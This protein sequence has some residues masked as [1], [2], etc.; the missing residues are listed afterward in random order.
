M[1]FSRAFLAA[2]VLACGPLIAQTP[3]AAPAEAAAPQH[4]LVNP[5]L[6]S[7]PDP[8][9]TYR[10]GSY[11]VMH[12][13]GR[14]LTI[15]KTSRIED[16]ASAE[17][18]VVWRAPAAGPYSRDIWAPELHYLRG[19]WYI[20]F[21]A[22]AG[23]NASHRVWVLE[24]DSADPL[25]GEWRMKGKAA[26]AGDRWAIDATVFEDGKRLFMVWSGWEAGV[27]G[28][29]NLYIAELSNPW[30]VKGARVKISSPEFPWEKVG[31]L[32]Q[33]RDP[34]E[35]P[36]ANRLDPPHVDVNEG[37][38]ILRHG[39]RIFIVYSAAGCWTDNYSLGML[40]AETG[41]DLLRPESWKK[42]PLPVFWQSP[43]AGV[44]GPGHGSFFQ[45]PD[46]A[47]DWLL[48]HANPGPGQGCG[49]RR[50][51]H[52]QRFTWKPDGTPDFGRPIRA[53]ERAAPPSGEV[54]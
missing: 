49:G 1:I 12:T 33:K 27:N 25:A 36:G 11:Y 38:E 37:P 54:P 5:L 28:A 3:Q 34:E 24:N 29:Q 50:A 18:K 4:V 51:P 14:D 52:A 40:A 35:N 32:K 53:G 45:S 21:A 13:T 44:Y 23:T 26:D 31:D 43:N 2:A 39:N 19:K 41:S 8:W 30:T 42:S 46:G 22:D 20:Y 10:D 7:G 17:K 9:V 16:L 15:R 47:E 6:T 48:Y